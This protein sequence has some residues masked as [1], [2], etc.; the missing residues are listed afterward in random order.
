MDSWAGE[1][2]VEGDESGGCEFW[3]GEPLGKLVV[4]DGG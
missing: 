2:V 1:L 3:T 4:S